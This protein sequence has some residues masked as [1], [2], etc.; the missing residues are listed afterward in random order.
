MAE[1]ILM[2][3]GT[4]G[5]NLILNGRARFAVTAEATA[6]AEIEGTVSIRIEDG[7]G[8]VL[9]ATNE[10]IHIPPDDPKIVAV[11]STLLDVKSGK[12]LTVKAVSTNKSSRSITVTLRAVE[13]G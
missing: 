7:A 1:I 11:T 12:Q 5:A 10:S 6:I 3:Q 2:A 13:V 8:A 4:F 9:S